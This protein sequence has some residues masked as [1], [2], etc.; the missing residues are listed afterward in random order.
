MG[1]TKMETLR[2]SLKT[3]W[4]IKTSNMDENKIHFKNI[5]WEIP[6]KGIKQKIFLKG[7]QRIRL[8]RFYDD[9]IEDDWCAKGHI[10]Y[11]TDGGMTVDFN[12]DMISYKKGDGLWIEEGIENRHK[13]IIAKGKMVELILVEAEQEK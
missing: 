4:S 11:V 6:S 13:V 7:A 8:L 12:G 9:F 1:G 2:P 3:I 5:D 10:G